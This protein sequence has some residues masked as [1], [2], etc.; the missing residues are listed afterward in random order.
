MYGF[1]HLE[2]ELSLGHLVVLEPRVHVKAVL[3]GGLEEGGL[4]GMGM[5][6]GCSESDT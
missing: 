6:R 5:G 4:A 2:G 3:V 1:C